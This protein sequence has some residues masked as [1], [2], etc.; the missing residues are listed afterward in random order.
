MVLES[1]C[2]AVGELITLDKSMK[3][4]LGTLGG[5]VQNIVAKMKMM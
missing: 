5:A 3:L 1:I 4:L 2:G